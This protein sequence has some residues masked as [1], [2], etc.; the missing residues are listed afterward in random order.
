MLFRKK[1]LIGLDIG[2]NSVKLAE[3]DVSPRQ[4]I[5]NRFSMVPTPPSA[6][7]NGGIVEG[8]LI[9]EAVRQAIS[10]LKTKR[11]IVSSGLWGSSVVVKRI[12]MPH[13]EEGLVSEQIRWEAEQYIPY[14]INEVNIEYKILNLSG[15]TS[16]NMEVLLVAAMQDSV[17]KIAEIIEVAGLSCS[18][19]D[20]EGFA[21]ANC[22]ER[23]YGGENSGVIGLFNIGSS[24][25][26]F[27][28]LEKGEIV[29]CRD[30]PVGGGT[31]TAALHRSMGISM[32]E[33]ESM[34][35]SASM[36]HPTPDE[37]T[38]VI[39]S[40]HE[41]VLEELKSGLEFFMNTNHSQELTQSYISGGGSRTL[42]LG[43]RMKEAYK[44][45]RMDPL[46]G[47]KC[48]TKKVPMDLINSIK[49]FG[50]VAIGLGLREPGDS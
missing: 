5:L 33:A 24:V 16:E 37:A 4:V 39:E 11:K 12:N 50:V 26:N 41:I 46:I 45:V 36:G 2:T 35:I 48:N 42:G 31:Y 10:E 13:M 40:T 44:T 43:E 30:I 15:E 34:K 7:I 38:S 22:F 23:N 47:I 14:D 8:G 25:T 6:I 29:F 17:F 32:E 3:L 9:S 19:L 18:I 49:D 20:I 28:I 21:L 27:V 1:K